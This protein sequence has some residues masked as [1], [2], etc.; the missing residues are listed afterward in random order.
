M[1]KHFLFFSW[2]L[3]SLIKSGSNLVNSIGF[4]MLVIF[5]APLSLGTNSDLLERLAPLIIWTAAIL[6]TIMSL[7]RIFKYD[8]QD[9]SLDM[10]NISEISLETLVLIKMLTHWITSG[11]PLVIL[12]P[13]LAL[14]FNLPEQAYLWVI[15]S[16]FVGTL[17]LSFIGTIGASLTVGVKRETVVLTLLVLPLY[18]PILFFGEK[19]IDLGS[20]GISPLPAL[21]CLCGISIL[22]LALTPFLASSAI[23]MH[24]KY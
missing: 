5:L 11:L 8:M 4:F 15:I 12:S 2:E 7:E 24:W 20:R 6:A 3:R 13:L 19:V 23:R 14:T 16:L 22:S 10:L 18:F 17:G 1:N 21:V 9:G